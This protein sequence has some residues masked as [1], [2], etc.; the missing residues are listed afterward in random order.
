[1]MTVSSG[2]DI[3][4][5]DGLMEASVGG[6]VPGLA[7]QIGH[8]EELVTRL[9]TRTEEAA[10]SQQENIINGNT[11]EG[12]LSL[13]REAVSDKE[14]VMTEMMTKFSKNRQILTNNWE[15]AE[16]EVKASSK[17]CAGYYCSA[18][19]YCR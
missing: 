13:L 3:M 4:G 7:E 18:I 14:R 16:S 10:R 8:I 9:V 11:E 19:C 1:M 15:Q 2:S 12:E 6:G 5:G 17:Y